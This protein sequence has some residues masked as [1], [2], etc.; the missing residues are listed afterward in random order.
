[1]PCSG[2]G[3]VRGRGGLRLGPPPQGA[4]RG[5]GAGG[6]QDTRTPKRVCRISGA[7]GGSAREKGLCHPVSVGVAGGAEEARCSVGGRPQLLH[8]RWKDRVG[9]RDPS[10]GLT[11]HP[12]HLCAER[13][14]AEPLLMGTVEESQRPAARSCG[15]RGGGASSSRLQEPCP[16]ARLSQGHLA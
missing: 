16:P 5:G 8:R 14:L 6:T 15:W 10:P 12:T 13:L 1:M 9:G 7:D 4:R 3:T 11:H 2:P